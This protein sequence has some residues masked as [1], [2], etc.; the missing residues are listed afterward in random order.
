[1]LSL[2][3]GCTKF[4]C[5]RK[6]GVNMPAKRLVP[7]HVVPATTTAAEVAPVPGDVKMTTTT[8]SATSADSVTS[9]AVAAV[10]ASQTYMKVSASICFHVSQHQCNQLWHIYLFY[11]ESV[12]KVHI[13]HIHISAVPI[14]FFFHF[15][16]N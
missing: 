1:M 2:L 5:Y 6:V 8:S 14:V 15:E 11:M 9:A 4:C 7:A 16:S 12:L 10:I 3:V 13:K